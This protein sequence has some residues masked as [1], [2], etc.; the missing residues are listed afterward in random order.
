MVREKVGSTATV[1][2]S[3]VRKI[4]YR[5]RAQ[6]TLDLLLLQSVVCGVSLNSVDARI[7]KDSYAFWAFALFASLPFALYEVVAVCLLAP[8]DVDVVV[9]DAGFVWS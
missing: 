4:D 9:D 7:R 3:T 8:E 1:V 6:V 5:S 2:G